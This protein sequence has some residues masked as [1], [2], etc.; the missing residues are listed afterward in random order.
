MDKKVFKI[1][2]TAVCSVLCFT[3]VACGKTETSQGGD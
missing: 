3:G 2:A 1:I